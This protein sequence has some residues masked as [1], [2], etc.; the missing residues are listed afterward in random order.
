MALVDLLLPPACASCGRIGQVLCRDCVAAFQPPGDARDRFVAADPGIVVGESV[1]LALAAFAYQGAVRRTLQRFKYGGAARLAGPLARAALPA[2]DRLVQ[3]IGAAPLVPI[4]VHPERGRQRGYNQAA[5][6]AVELGRARQLQ[7]A[8]V[9]ERVRPTTRQH[10][11]DRA[12]RLHN[13]R[14]AFAPARGARAPPRAIMVDDILTTSATVEA[15]A[16]VLHA[17]GSQYVYA[18]ALAR[19]V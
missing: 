4:P 12:G 1:L 19:E 6:L 18:F 17:A 10:R 15:C 14:D 11:L 8:G 16:A 2:F 5:L 7:I 3:A 13:L 9:L